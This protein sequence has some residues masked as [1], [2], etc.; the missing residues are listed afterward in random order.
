MHPGCSQ[1]NKVAWKMQE[2]T[3]NIFFIPQKGS[4]QLLITYVIN[5]LICTYYVNMYIT[6]ISEQLSGKTG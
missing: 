3:Y 5:M 1:K 2:T 6:Y 4:K